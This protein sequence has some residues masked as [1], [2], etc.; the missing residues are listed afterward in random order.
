ERFGELRRG[1]L[2]RQPADERAGPAELLEEAAVLRVLLE[3]LLDLHAA[4]VIE[5]VVDVGTQPG[6]DDFLVLGHGGDLLVFPSCLARRTPA[7]GEPAAAARRAV[8][9]HP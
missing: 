2:A 1:R 8:G 4:L 3:V 5:L 7:R 9:R 6:L